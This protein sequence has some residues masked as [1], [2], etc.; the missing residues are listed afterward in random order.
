MRAR[1]PSGETHASLSFFRCRRRS[2]QFAGGDRY[3]YQ[4]ANEQGPAA[5]LSGTLD[6]VRV[7]HA[8]DWIQLQVPSGGAVSRLTISGYYPFL[9]AVRANGVM[10]VDA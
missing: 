4:L 2:N 7:G 3:V 1:A 8:A 9:P 5:A 6:E 10:L